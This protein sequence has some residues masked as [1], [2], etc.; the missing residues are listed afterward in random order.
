MVLHVKNATILARHFWNHFPSKPVTMGIN[1]NA[2]YLS[3]KYT[4]LRYKSDFE[5]YPTRYN[6]DHIILNK[7]DLFM[8]DIT[9]S[10]STSVSF[11]ERRRNRY[12]IHYKLHVNNGECHEKKLSDISTLENLDLWQD[13]ADAKKLREI[14]ELIET[15]KDC[16]VSMRK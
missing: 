11:D 3:N 7:L 4:H 14:D 16:F 10:E 12:T 9:L 13:F 8:N 2:V 1:N 15:N 6:Y 5:V